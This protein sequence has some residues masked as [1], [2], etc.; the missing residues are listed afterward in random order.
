MSYLQE[1]SFQFWGF[2]IFGL[3][4]FVWLFGSIMAPFIVGFAVAYLLNPLVTKLQKRSIPR[5][6]SALVILIIFFAIVV[7]GLLMAAPIL[8]R[9]MLDFTS[10][11]PVALAWGEDWIHD[12]LPML[13]VP[14]YFEGLGG[15]DVS[16]WSSKAG[17]I[18][19]LGKNIVGNIFAGGLAVVGFISFVAL[20][21][22]VA[23][24]L[25]IDWA[26]LGDKA[27]DL[28]PKKNAGGI[29][30]ILVDI[31]KSL[32]GF[33]RGQ[34]TVCLLLGAF[35]AIALSLLGLQ[36]GFF[37][38]VSSGVLAIIPYVGSIFGLV[39]SV[40]LAFYQFG[41]WE[42]PAMALGIFVAGQLIEGNYLTPKLVGESV[43]LH[44]LW[45][46]FAL[47]AGGSLFGLVGMILAVPVAA[48]IAV[49]IRHGIQNYKKSAYYKGKK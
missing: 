4:A 23:F 34:L 47:M 31:D 46:I 16:A 44:P 1:K 33:I 18:L 9:E 35:Y 2:V 38:G 8:F 28:M 43:G 17:S 19:Q 11:I 27:N 40:G 32:S 15:F 13:D 39:A 10:L 22:I 6:L 5:W 24:Y 30:S 42:Y 25:M 45:V 20:M 36:Y 14:Q 37:V 21:P 48:V 7:L 41:G 49:F 12:A 29:K 26:R 3:V